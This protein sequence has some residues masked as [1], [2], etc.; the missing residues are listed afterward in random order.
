MSLAVLKSKHFIF[1]GLGTLGDIFPSLSMAVEMQ[2]RGHQVTML[3]SP[4]HAK[5][6]KLAGIAC[7]TLGTEADYEAALRNPDM[8]DIRKGMTV[9]LEASKSI[10]TAIPDYI[11]TLPAEQEGVL[12]VHPLGLLAADM[13]R[14]FRPD[15]PIIAAYLAPSN[16][17]TIHDPL[18]MGD[19]FIPSWLPTGIRRFLWSYVDKNFVDPV[20]LP[21]INQARQTRHLAPI[22]SM[23]SHMYAVPDL[24]ISLFP[25]WF[26]PVQADWPMPMYMGEFQLYDS[27]PDTDLSTE[28]Q[29]FLVA[30]QAPLIFTP[31]S[32][33]L[34]AAHYFD[35]ALQAV[36]K[37]GIRAIFLTPHREQ[38]PKELPAEILWQSYLPLRNILPHA[39]AIIH[40]GGIGTMAEAL[41]AGTPQLVTPLA[42]D[43]FDN[44]ARVKKLGVGDLLR[45]SRLNT[46]KLTSGLQQLLN[47]VAV[48]SNCAAVAKKFNSATYAKS[49]CDVIETVKIKQ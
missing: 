15:I 18:V 43:Q 10:F 8:W 17:R 7:H 21:I 25:A 37:L 42:F 9:V 45:M 27:Q 16:L 1:V 31:G 36:K 22:A 29:E 6:A 33:N 19:L 30:G 38:L 44:A 46:R 49:L 26:A 24:N 48:K 11:A 4:V 28:L 14:S 39:A 32:G 34:Q 35:C 23:A 12:I 5:H 2:R 41:R 47:S 20:A 3:L 40:H 13:V